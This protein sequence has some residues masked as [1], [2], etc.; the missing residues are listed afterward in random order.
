VNTLEPS[1]APDQLLTALRWR[2]ATKVFDPTRKISEDLWAAVEQS[3]VLSAS[4]FGFQP[5]RFLVIND[6]ALRQQLL[7]HSFKQRQV[8]DAS[9]YLV[10][11]GRTSVT[12]EEIDA[13]IARTAEVR[14]VAPESLSR[15]RD[16][17]TGSLLA[18]AFQGTAPAWAAN[19]IYLALGNLLTSAALLGLDA[20]PMEGFKPVEYDR[21][22]G[23]KEQGLTAV[24]CCAVGYRAAT[25]KYATLPKVRFPLDHLVRRL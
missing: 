10:F 1:V 12:A 7:E 19:Q 17:L 2:Y 21:V 13:F 9:H 22:L 18:E 24:V 25:D 20:C 16:M 11:A 8:V 23:L 14:G 4:S 15:F 3:L 5:Y 6:P